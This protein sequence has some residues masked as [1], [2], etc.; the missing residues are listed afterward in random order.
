VT[1]DRAAHVAA[2]D[3]GGGPTPLEANPAALVF[4]HVLQG[5]LEALF[6]PGERVLDLD[7]GRGAAASLL[8]SRGV[9]VVALDRLEGLAAAGSGFDGAYS[10]SGALDGA[11]LRA[12]GTALSGALRPGSAV[13]LSLLGPWPL[14]GL[15]RRLL[16]GMG[17]RRRAHAVVA[18]PRVP[19]YP[20]MA[21]TRRALGPMFTWTDA[22]SLGVLLPDPARES[23]VGEHPQAF[24]ML[25][26]IE[27]TVRRWPGLRELGDQLVLEGRRVAPG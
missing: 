2:S 6:R 14:P 24:A 19:R 11:D 9:R 4:R 3:P 12:V 8:A 15:L 17:E 16:T 13:L 20:T 5:R 23:W 18:L 1:A 25:A 21:E 27:R 10:T 26:M 22:Y 7:G